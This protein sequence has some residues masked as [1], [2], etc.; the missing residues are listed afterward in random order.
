VVFYVDI[1]QRAATAFVE[2]DTTLK[3]IQSLLLGSAMLVLAG[4][5]HAAAQSGPICMLICF[6]P[7]KFDGQKCTCTAPHQNTRV[8]GLVCPP[9]TTL[10][11]KRCRCVASPRGGLSLR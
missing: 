3:L 10:D 6:P 9:D 8:C 7:D 5:G 11:A 4:V 2:R 1:S